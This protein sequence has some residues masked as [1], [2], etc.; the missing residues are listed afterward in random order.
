MSPKKYQKLEN[1]LDRIIRAELTFRVGTRKHQDISAINDALEVRNRQI[2]EAHQKGGVAEILPSLVSGLFQTREGG[3]LWLPAARTSDEKY[4]NYLHRKGRFE[5]LFSAAVMALEDDA[6]PE[7]VSR[8]R[9]LF[10][11]KFAQLRELML[12]TGAARN[13]QKEA[14]MRSDNASGDEE[15]AFAHLMALAPL[16]ADLHTIENQCAELREDTWLAEALR[17]LQQAVR[18]AEKSIAEKSRKSAKTLFD[19]AGDIFQHYKSV[20]ATI[21]NMDRLTAQ[22]G[23]L[24]RYAGIFNDIGDKE[25]VGR[26]EGFVA[27]I[28][29]TLRKLQEE[30]A[31]QKAYETRMSAQQQAAVSDACDRFAEIREL[32]AQGRLTA[33]SQKKNA[34]RKLNKYRDTLIANGQRIMARDIDRFINATGI[35]KKAD[36]KPEGDRKEQADSFDYKKGFLI[37]LPI[38]IVLLWA[39]LLMLIL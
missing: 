19:Q 28:D 33:E 30:V 32:Y 27:A 10:D 21:P 37:L 18:K 34:G 31:Q 4:E 8:K 29:A 24:Q 13:M 36:K 17:Q 12:L 1:E 11:A 25:R 6:L 3:K 2:V 9:Q 22:K 23:E 35:G 26:I 20:P 15:G 38:T 5:T 39:V 16:R 7:I 14:D